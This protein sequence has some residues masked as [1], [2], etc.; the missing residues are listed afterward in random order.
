MVILNRNL[1]KKSVNI[2][3]I[4]IKKYYNYLIKYNSHIKDLK[5][6]KFKKILLKSIY[7][8]KN[9]NNLIKINYKN[10]NNNKYLLNINKKSHNDLILSIIFKLKLK[11]NLNLIK[12][13]SRRK[14]Y[15]YRKRVVLYKKKR[16]WNN[17]G[18]WKKRH[19]LKKVK[20]KI[21]KWKSFLKKIQ[22][23]NKNKKIKIENNNLNNF[24]FKKNK[25]KSCLLLKKDIVN[26]KKWLELF[27][28]D[29]KQDYNTLFEYTLE[30]I[31]LND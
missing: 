3:Y 27:I 12:R 25:K 15:N 2:K 23:I 10:L 4:Y 9:L 31:K 7:L 13:Y 8:K 24:I 20:V 29:K 17:L 5:L 22:K 6:Y 28:N 16:V 11:R 21:K 19:A 30:G 14:W 1:K 26:N 18:K